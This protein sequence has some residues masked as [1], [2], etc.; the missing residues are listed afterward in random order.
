MGRERWV[1]RL[2]TPIVKDPY[3][4]VQTS[5][6]TTKALA[7][8]SRPYQNFYNCLFGYR[9]DNFNYSEYPVKLGSK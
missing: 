3:S 4:H 8:T 1:I 9:V 6:W 2:S 5:V 7:R